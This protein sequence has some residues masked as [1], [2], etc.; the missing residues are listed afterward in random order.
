MYMNTVTYR[1]RNEVRL[2]RPGR[3]DYVLSAGTSVVVDSP[4][5]AQERGTGIRVFLK[6]SPSQFFVLSWDEADRAG[7]LPVT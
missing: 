2:P 3:E 5:L 6:N 4:A 7:M 1:T